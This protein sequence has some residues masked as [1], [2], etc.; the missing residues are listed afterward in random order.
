MPAIIAVMPTCPGGLH[1]FRLYDFMDPW[2][3]YMLTIIHPD[4][5]CMKLMLVKALKFRRFFYIIQKLLQSKWRSI[6]EYKDN[7]DRVT[8]AQLYRKYQD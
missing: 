2:E 4:T 3:T 6:M 7:T 8:L 1:K 5:I